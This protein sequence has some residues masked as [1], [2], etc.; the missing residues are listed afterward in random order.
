MTTSPRCWLACWLLLPP[1]PPQDPSD[2]VALQAALLLANLSRFDFPHPWHQL[3]PD[4]AGAA[5]LD[6]PLPLRSKQ[7]AVTALKHVLRALR[8]GWV[9]LVGVDEVG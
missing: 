3:L 4:L 5:A 2:R 9:A 8:G 7:R 6:G 1:P